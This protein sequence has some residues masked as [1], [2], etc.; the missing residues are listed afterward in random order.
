VKEIYTST[1]I[2]KRQTLASDDNRVV[3]LNYE[4]GSMATLEYFATG[5]KEFPKEYFEIHFDEKTIVIDDYKSIEGYGVKVRISKERISEKG[6]LEEL[7]VLYD[8][9]TGKRDRWP[10]EL[11]DLLQTTELTF[12][13][14]N[15]VQRYSNL[16]T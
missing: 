3:V 13:V 1:L 12:V 10:I 2:P 9:L 5:S 16:L 11:W 8:V 15:Q 7:E 4:D 14:S 6:H